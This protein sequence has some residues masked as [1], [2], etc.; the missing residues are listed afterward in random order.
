[1]FPCGVVCE[2]EESWCYFGPFW[3]SDA[4]NRYSN[5]SFKQKAFGGN[6]SH[7]VSYLP[8]S[9]LWTT[10]ERNRFFNSCQEIEILLDF[11]WPSPLNT[12]VDFK[13][14]TNDKPS[15][16]RILTKTR[17]N[18]SLHVTCE[19]K[20]TIWMLYCEYLI[21]RYFSPKMSVPYKQLRLKMIHVSSTQ[22]IWILL[23]RYLI[24]SRKI[25]IS[26]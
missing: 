4:E 3:D 10:N 23:T 7:H 6:N 24:D 1:M 11:S 15:K 17:E 19:T 8:N 26:K 5:F 21:Y 2:R 12:G 9:Y 16:G 13:N 20:I 18:D 25:W 22:A 14:T